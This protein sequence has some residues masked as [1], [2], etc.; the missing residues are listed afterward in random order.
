MH[1]LKS[2]TL[3]EDIIYYD[4]DSY[5]IKNKNYKE[6]FVPNILSDI[7]FYKHTSTP[8]PNTHL[9]TA[10]SQLTKTLAFYL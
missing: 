9:L 5:Y 2:F 8:R 4:H 10:S 1:Y 6:K 3:F 7:N